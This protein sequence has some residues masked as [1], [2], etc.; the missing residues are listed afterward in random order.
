MNKQLVLRLH[1]D[2]LDS[3]SKKIICVCGRGFLERSLVST[4]QPDVI[5]HYP[6]KGSL[7]VEQNS[8]SCLQSQREA[9][10]SLGGII[11]QFGT[12]RRFSQYSILRVLW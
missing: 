10:A 12:H 11:G 1:V 9:L 5:F 7:V 8:L 3:S 4:K 6:G 2:V